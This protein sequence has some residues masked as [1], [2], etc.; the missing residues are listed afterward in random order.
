MRISGPALDAHPVAP[1]DRIVAIDI[2][3]GIAL[4]GVLAI[5]VT[6]E[7]RVSIFEQ[8]LHGR[9][10]GSWLDR[11]LHSFLMIGVDLK[12]FALFSLL[13]GVGLASNCE[14]PDR[15]QSCRERIL[16]WTAHVDVIRCNRAPVLRLW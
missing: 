12:T 4:F 11:A 10:E 1:A 14:R 2:V 8:F 3:R 16:S 9:I 6:T 15:W 13:F 5:N 7:F